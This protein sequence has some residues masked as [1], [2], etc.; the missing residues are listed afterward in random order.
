MCDYLSEEFKKLNVPLT[1]YQWAH[2]DDT[3]VSNYDNLVPDSE[4][5]IHY[6]FTLDTFQKRAFLKIYQG[7]HVFVSAHTSAG[8]TITAEWAIALSIAKGRK[9]IYTSPI[10]A[11]SNQKF[12]DFRVKFNDIELDEIS[13]SPDQYYYSD[14]D[15]YG[16]G[17]GGHIYDFNAYQD[18]SEDEKVGIITGD[19]Q[20]HKTAPCLIL[21][22]EILRTMIYDNDPILQELEWVVFDEIHYMNDPERGR[23]WEEVIT[24]L[25]DHVNMLF[26]SATTPNS[27]EFSEWVGRERNRPV[28]VISTPK[29]PI[30]LEHYLHIGTHDK[31]M[32]KYYKTEEM[33]RA[34]YLD[35]LDPTSVD[36][37]ERIA[38][39]EKMKF[40]TTKIMEDVDTQLTQNDGM[41]LVVDRK[42]TY[43][44]L[45]EKTVKRQILEKR[46]NNAQKSAIS[47]RQSRHHWLSLFKLLEIKRKFPVVVFVFSKKMVATL[48][49]HL[50]NKDFT[51]KREKSYLKTFVD[52]CLKKLK[53]EDRLL[54]QITN[55]VEML[56]RG[57]AIHH[58]G[59]LPIL[60]EMTEIL[61]QRGF[62]RILFA[63]ETFAMG[64]NMPTRSVVFS[65]VSK[66]DG[67]EFRD[68]L[69]GEYTQMSG[70]AGRRGLDDVGTVI[71]THWKP[72]QTSYK[73][74]IS[75]KPLLLTSRFRLTYQTILSMFQ[76]N[77]IE[78]G[79]TGLL[80]SSFSEFGN[81][82]DAHQVAKIARLIKLGERQLKL[83]K[84]QL[85]E[86]E[87]QDGLDIWTKVN[88]ISGLMTKTL[89]DLY[90]PKI[91]NQLFYPGR[92]ILVWPD[93]QLYP[94]P[95]EI[96]MVGDHYLTVQY[97]S[98]HP[99]NS[100]SN[101]PSNPPDQSGSDNTK[102]FQITYDW[103]LA[104]CEDITVSHEIYPHQVTELK[105]LPI[106]RLKLPFTSSHQL[107]QISELLD[108]IYRESPSVYL[109]ETV[110]LIHDNYWLEEKIGKLQLEASDQALSLFPD[111]HK[112]IQVLKQLKFIDQ[113]EVLSLK[114][115]IAT[116]INTCH[117]LVLTEFMMEGGLMSM[118]PPQIAALLSCLVSCEA[119]SGTQDYRGIGDF[120]MELY[121]RLKTLDE[122]VGRIQETQTTLGLDID[123]EKFR[124]ECFNTSLVKTVYYWASGEDF[125]EIMKYTDTMEGT[126]VRSIMRLDELCQE[127]I[128]SVEVIGDPSITETMEKVSTLLRR[129]IVFCGSLY[130]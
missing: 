113:D 64:I 44:E 3:D 100:Q 11:L 78:K 47:F 130:I 63:T 43:D 36:I 102:P 114:G 21:T 18:N 65:S 96:T 83:L 110:K 107:L 17:G 29:R 75:G 99:S 69:P 50:S 28:Y 92:K 79:V 55:T 53:P 13:N 89:E 16:Y 88:Q 128:R 120:D 46:G 105:H 66:H 68:L 73:S 97:L 123:P 62:V 95:M 7:Q 124:R 41:Y 22:T 27:M 82:K 20:L 35:K 127:I 101:S 72:S 118:T 67:V 1:E 34:D 32:V 125:A 54:P 84:P 40:K 51:Y 39:A 10:K 80:R 129:D 19:I 48:S 109:P 85:A 122:M 93:T 104:I 106:K 57:I 56:M 111:Y 31:D 24:L 58:G 59:L 2:Q 119:K 30:P 25:P 23:V 33:L 9:A 94:Q 98:S 12:R 52:K 37:S 108:Q 116:R 8:K 42:N 115:R 74:L 14:E 60:K 70:R 61:F 77:N 87:A 126:I 4:R 38:E 121:G 86:A 6:N 91:F 117:E 81:Q 112:R 76:T 90:A 45:V 71:V 49:E 26:L 103:V 5:P 15:D